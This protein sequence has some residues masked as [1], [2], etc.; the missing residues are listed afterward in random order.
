MVCRH[1]GIGAV[2]EAPTRIIRRQIRIIFGEIGI[3][4]VEGTVRVARDTVS[5]GGQSRYHIGANKAAKY[6]ATVIVKLRLRIF[7]NFT[8][9]SRIAAIQREGIKIDEVLGSRGYRRAILLLGHF[10]PQ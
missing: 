2:I 1:K 7:E 6:A 9:S 3:C 5:L 4:P 8:V 10:I